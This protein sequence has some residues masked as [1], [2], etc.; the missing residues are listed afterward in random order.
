[1]SKEPQHTDTSDSGSA[2]LKFI[3]IQE[4]L[5]TKGKTTRRGVA[6]ALDVP[7]AEGIAVSQAIEGDRCRSR[8]RSVSRRHFRGGNS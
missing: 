3:T 6:D 4:I 8:R 7:A 1:M 5:T 2:A